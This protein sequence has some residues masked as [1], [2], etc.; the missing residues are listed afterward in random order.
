M[1]SATIQGPGGLATLLPYLLGYH[2]RDSVVLVTL[3]DHIV[4]MAVRADFPPAGDLASVA[5]ALLEPAVR[6]RRTRVVLCGF[7]TSTGAAEP[8]LTALLNRC[9][10]VGVSVL[11]AVVVRAG[12]YHSLISENR[13]PPGGSPVPS[14]ESVPAALELIALGCAPLP[15]R[16]AI[17]A[18]ITAD[19]RHGPA[20]GAAI[21][22]GVGL[23]QTFARRRASARAWA[24]L[25]DTESGVGEVPIN[26]EGEFDA[27]VLA[28]PARVADAVLGLRDV[29]WRDGLTAW[30]APGLLP[31]DEVDTG[32]RRL[33]VSTLP[34]PL[35]R[36]PGCRRELLRRLL[37]LARAVPDGCPVEA[38]S[39][40]VLL[41]QVAWVGGDGTLARAAVTRALRVQPGQ[42]LATVMSWVLD[43]GVRPP[44]LEVPSARV[45][46]G[47]PP[48]PG[49]RNG[50]AGTSSPG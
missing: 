3:K 29:P 16:A 26:R 21:S 30:L 4:D 36:L 49:P 38:A 2:P 25:L 44:R 19:Q 33:L 42:R 17:D 34:G 9:R 27:G 20:V 1:T 24:G 41:A 11:D 31:V 45:E 32:V 23:P 50:P 7:E 35:S 28:S 47:R 12:R 48:P 13:C 18:L 22:A 37:L 43:H 15:S 39:M 46:P 10:E 14:P 8:L 6:H 5:D 40:C